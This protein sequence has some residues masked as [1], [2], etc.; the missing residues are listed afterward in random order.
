MAKKNSAKQKKATA[1]VA[2][3]VNTA[4][5][6]TPVE[7]TAIHVDNS[8]VPAFPVN[9]PPTISASRRAFSEFIEIADLETIQTFITT[10]SSFPESENIKILWDRAFEEGYTKGRHSQE[11]KLEATYDKGYKHGF[12]EGFEEGGSAK[13]EHFKMGL[14]QGREDEH[15]GWIE[16]GHGQHCL[17]AAF[18]E[19]SRTR[20]EPVATTIDAASQTETP[21][22]LQP[23]PPKSPSSEIGT[24]TN[25]PTSTFDLS[26]KFEPPAPIFNAASQTGFQLV[27]ATS[28]NPTLVEREKSTSPSADISESPL[29]PTTTTPSASSVSYKPITDEISI[30]RLTGLARDSPPDSALGIVW[31]RALEEGKNISRSETIETEKKEAI[32]TTLTFDTPTSESKMSYITPL[33]HSNTVLEPPL[34]KASNNTPF[35][36]SD[37]ACDLEPATLLYPLPPT[38]SGLRDL[39]ALSSGANPWRSLQHCK[40]R[41]RRQ[42]NQRFRPHKTCFYHPQ[43]PIPSLNY[44]HFVHRRH[45]PPAPAPPFS[46]TSFSLNW[47]QDPRL[48]D[49]SQA[50][51]ALGWVRR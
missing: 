17:E 21:I 11:K 2:P 34:S 6:S 43:A 37:E 5:S 47:D 10:A 49:L 41:G 29:S 48:A 13:L 23:Q 51:K 1:A 15:S 8:T 22:Q 33:E 20:T 31:R 45:Y 36:W 42:I 4:T 46:A 50:L 26:T 44:S 12:E 27:A 32:S 30:E 24:Q 7:N 25:S 19:D 18:R 16:D 35:H 14:E 39:S 9:T 38:N 40:G 3:L 28:P